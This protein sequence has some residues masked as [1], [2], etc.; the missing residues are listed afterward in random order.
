MEAWLAAA[1]PW[2]QSM[3]GWVVKFCYDFYQSFIYD[4]RYQYITKG[5][6]NTLLIT[7]FALLV[8]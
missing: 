1:P 6:G 2:L 3:P 8:G 7:F 5:L 4:N